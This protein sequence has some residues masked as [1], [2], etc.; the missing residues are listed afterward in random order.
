MQKSFSRHRKLSKGSPPFCRQKTS[1]SFH[2]FWKTSILLSQS[3]YTDWLGKAPEP[4]WG[5][6]PH[7]KRKNP[8]M[9]WLMKY[10]SVFSKMKQ[11]S[12][13]SDNK[14]ATERK[15]QEIQE[16][17]PQRWQ[18]NEGKNIQLPTN[19]FCVT[20]SQFANASSHSIFK[21]HG[22]SFL[23]ESSSPWVKPAT[24]AP[25]GSVTSHT[26]Q[27]LAFW[28]QD[29]LQNGAAVKPRIILLWK[30]L[31]CK[32]PCLGPAAHVQELCFSSGPCYLRNL[33]GRST[34]A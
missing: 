15:S 21:A 10:L 29:H 13:W 31:H 17:N 4:T 16:I 3:S 9:T 5:L 18:E 26:K 28:V 12:G 2:L 1:V 7:E 32:K 27:G 14:T 11:T 8:D 19:L 6:S 25:T 20:V 22:V 23:E 30:Q 33:H 24:S 34:H